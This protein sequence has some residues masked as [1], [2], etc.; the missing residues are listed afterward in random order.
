M[1]PKPKAVYPSTVHRVTPSDPWGHFPFAL[2]SF[3][4]LQLSKVLSGKR[5]EGIALLWTIQVGL[6]KIPWVASG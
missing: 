2:D 6:E 4:S 5:R 3:S 1:F